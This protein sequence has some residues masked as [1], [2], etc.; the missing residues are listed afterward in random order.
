MSGY[1]VKF[2]LIAYLSYRVGKFAI[3]EGYTQLDDGADADYHAGKRFYDDADYS[4]A[5]TN[6]EKSAN[7]GHF[8]SLYL[9]GEAYEKGHHYG[10][11][12]AKAAA[13]YYKASQKGYRAA[14]I[15]YHAILDSFS[16]EEKLEFDSQ[17][18]EPVFE[19]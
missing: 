2:A 4:Q 6:L 13:C 3:K 19:T 11:D 15:R 8:I 12:P 5:I 10:R 16:R 17:L 14:T 9:L 18:W 1:V 7:R